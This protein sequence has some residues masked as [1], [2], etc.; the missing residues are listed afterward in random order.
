LIIICRLDTV[1]KENGLKEVQM[2]VALV[3][4]HVKK[5]S[6]EIF[7]EASIENAKNSL[8]EPGFMR[9]DIMQQDDDP[10]KFV[11]CEIYKDMD[12]SARHKESP[13][14]LKW[15][16]IVDGIMEETRYSIKY[17]NVFPDVF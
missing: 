2:I 16:G 9:F 8:N 1:E 15:R 13:H 7:K 3:F 6:E 5:G 17:T 4:I 14:Y 12:V 11:F 10:S